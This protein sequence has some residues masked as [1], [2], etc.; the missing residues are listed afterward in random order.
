[1]N[2]SDRFGTDGTPRLYFAPMEG[3]TGHIFRRAFAAHF[4]APDRF[5]TPFIAPDSHVILRTKEKNDVMPE[6]NIGLEII[7]QIITNNYD[8]FTDTAKYLAKL[9][10]TEVNLNLG[11][12]SGTVTAKGKGSGFLAPERRMQ[13]ETFLECIFTDCP[14]DI[15]IKTRIGIADEA[16]YEALFRVFEKYPVKELTIH[17]R[18][19]KDFYKNTPHMEVF[20]NAYQNSRHS[21]CYNGDINTVEDYKR[22]VEEFPR[23]TGVMIGRGALRNPWLF[24]EIFGEER[25]TDRGESLLHFQKQLIHDY[26][27]VLSGERDVL[28]KL[29]EIWFYLC[30]R[31]KDQEYFAKKVK[32]AKYISEIELVAEEYAAELNGSRSTV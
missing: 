11:C 25:Q 16:E 18:L 9:G 3:I 5:Y 4:P 17:P 22:L 26:S 19:Q 10:Y 29:K 28:F 15:S 20:R 21:I 24:G 31:A 23:L 32:K 6:H 2:N 27:E 13:L 14:I 7:P 1:M 8:A 12:P 30:Q